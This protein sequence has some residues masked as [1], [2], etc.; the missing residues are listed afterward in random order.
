MKIIIIIPARYSSSRFPGKPLAE[1]CC[2][3]MIWWTYSQAK[4]VRNVY[5]VLVATDDE[6]ILKKCLEL[7]IKCELTSKNCKTS[8]ERLFEIAKNHKADLYIAVNGDEPLIKPELI[9]KIIP[10]EINASKQVFNLMTSI[11]D[12][13][14]A[15]DP[16]NIK[17]VVDE[18]S[19]ALLFSRSIIPYPKSSL[20]YVFYKHVGV[21]AYTFDALSFFASTKRGKLEEIEDINELRF[22][23]HGVPVKMVKVE[24]ETLSVDT[25]KDLEYIENIIKGQKQ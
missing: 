22:I 21:I 5:D 25:P 7:D 9:E 24:C 3:P 4:R 6:R 2:K 10:S 13:V 12:P 8:T 11:K 16:S 19:N 14:H 18:N 20:N 1:I 15:I 17:V 23:E